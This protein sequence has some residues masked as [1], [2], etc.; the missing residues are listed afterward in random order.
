MTSTPIGEKSIPKS[1]EINSTIFGK[2]EILIKNKPIIIQI[3][4]KR[5]SKYLFLIKNRIKN[6]NIIPIKNAISLE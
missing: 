4:E 3:N 6:I 1:L 5:C 2:K